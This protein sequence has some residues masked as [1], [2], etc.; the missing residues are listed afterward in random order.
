[1]RNRTVRAMEGCPF[2]TAMMLICGC[3]KVTLIQALLDANRPLRYSELRD[4]A[5]EVSDR[6]L[7][8]QLRELADDGL[9]ICEVYPEVPPRVEYA[10]TPTARRLEPIIA[11]H[12]AWGGFG[13]E[14]R[15]R[16]ARRSLPL[17]CLR[18][19]LPSRRPR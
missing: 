12:Q 11:E 2:K 8:R 19:R 9:V 6:T 17:G 5:G 18:R 4:A 1:M 3:W 16:T 13:S 15:A 10:L 14:F 7:T